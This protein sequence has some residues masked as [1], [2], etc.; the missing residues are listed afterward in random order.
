MPQKRILTSSFLRN[1]L[2][3]QAAV[4][5]A[6]GPELSKGEQKRLRQ[7]KDPNFKPQSKANKEATPANE[8]PTGPSKTSMEPPKRKARGIGFDEKMEKSKKQKTENTEDQK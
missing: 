8:A 3:L 2:A 7:A 6:P 5:K 1:L 4:R